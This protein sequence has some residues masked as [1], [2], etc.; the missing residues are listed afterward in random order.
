MNSFQLPRYILVLCAL[1]SIGNCGV[2]EVQHQNMAN[3]V[4]LLRNEI[5]PVS[6]R[7]R[8]AVSSSAHIP[9]ICKDLDQSDPITFLLSCNLRKLEAQIDN[10]NELLPLLTKIRDI[11]RNAL[12]DRQEGIVGNCLER[13]QALLAA[14]QELVNYLDKSLVRNRDMYEGT[15]LAKVLEMLQPIRESLHSQTNEVR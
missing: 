6:S 15:P 9:S 12:R 1:V 4:V 14:R 5:I 13:I 10:L 2:I 7:Y 11:G 8:R 3:D